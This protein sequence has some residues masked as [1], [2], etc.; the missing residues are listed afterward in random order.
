MFEFAEETTQHG[1]KIKV[2]GVGGGGGNAVNTMIR[3]GLSGVE[4]IAANTDRQ[5][6][7]ASLATVKIA[8][9]G[10][11]TKG[12]GA[13]SNPEVGR[14]AAMEDYAK[15]SELLSGADMI[16]VTAGM[17]GGTGTGAAPIIA[18]IAKEIGALTVGVV[19]KPFMFEGK[20]RM[21]QAEQGL[22]NLRESVDSLITIPN[23][24][25]LSIAGASLSMLETF[26][27]ADEV[28]LNAVQGISDLINH[29]GLINSDFADV[30]TI[31][32]NKGL[33]LMGIGQA[34][35]E[36]RALEA[37]RA[38]ISSPL[39]EDVSIHGATGI[40]INITGG[41]NLKI[42]EVNEATMLIMEAADEDAE[43][44]FGTVIDESMKDDVKV[45]VIA[46][47]L[48]PKE[49]IIAASM[50]PLS[51]EKLEAA[52][53]I[54]AAAPQPTA[55][56]VEASSPVAAAEVMA[57]T[58]V[59]EPIAVEPIAAAIQVEAAPI[60]PPAPAMALDREPAL[61]NLGASPNKLSPMEHAEALA[62]SFGDADD[63]LT[64]PPAPMQ[65]TQPPALP[66]ML[67]KAPL[68]KPLATSPSSYCD[69][70]LSDATD[71]D[72]E[73][74]A[75]PANGQAAGATFRDYGSQPQA[76]KGD[77]LNRAKAI[78]QKLGLTNLTDDEY[79]IPTFIRRQQEHDV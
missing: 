57:A 16:F 26:K 54:Q 34:T 79:D 41:S 28:L 33:A 74:F 1:A 35:G 18:K 68:A 3:M 9:G 20:K 25:L 59:A 23:N 55:T 36:G 40:I 52:V 10:E 66:P 4:F 11:L 30:K 8:L 51:P 27:K 22:A 32:Q 69:D 5:A 38:A 78:A 45:T 43:I 44:I 75:L 2:I 70:G 29:T 62:R 47:G 61:G 49:Q 73:D 58:V 46:T 37:A 7:E 67:S 24:R 53:I 13:G 71:E 21:K 19:T 76:K 12:L 65:M 63:A 60:A 14:R 56:P 50:V 48:G 15:L 42:H 31:M 6:L 39:L 17:G 72:E 77:D 64:L